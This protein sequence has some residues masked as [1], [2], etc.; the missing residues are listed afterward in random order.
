MKRTDVL[1]VAAIITL[2]AGCFGFSWRP[3]FVMLI[4]GF[5]VA[6]QK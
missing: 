2:T 3:F 1:D 4:V 5:V 6:F